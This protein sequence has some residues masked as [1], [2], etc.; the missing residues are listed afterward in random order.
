M[1]ID[2]SWKE[3]LAHTWQSYRY[4]VLAALLVWGTGVYMGTRWHYHSHP[5]TTSPESKTIPSTKKIIWTC[6]MDPQIRMPKPGKCPICSMDLI[7]VADTTEDVGSSSRRLTIS[8]SAK[9]LAEIRTS[10][11]QR[12]P[13]FLEV[14]MVGR[15]AYDET[16]IKT[17]TAWIPGRLE[18]MYV[19]YTGV[20][21]RRGDHLVKIY[22]PELLAAQQELLQSLQAVQRTKRLGQTGI[23]FDTA[24]MALFSAR[25]KLELLG[26]RRWQIQN[27]ENKGKAEDRVNIYSPIGGIVTQ[28]KALEGMYVQTGTPLY[29]IADLSQ[30]WV[31]F[32]AYER[33]LS[34]L[35]PGQKVTF[36]TLA[37]PGQH[38]EGNI[39]YIDPML[40]AQ[41]RTIGVR[42][43]AP[44][45]HGLLK[46]DMFVQGSVHVSLNAQGR[47]RPTDRTGQWICPMHP[48]IIRPRKTFCPLCG[49]SLERIHRNASKQ[50]DKDPLVIPKTAPLLT[51]KRAVVYVRVPKTDKPTYE[52]REII[53]GSHTDQFYVVLSGLQEGEEV[54]EHGAFKLDSELQ[55]HARPS[56]M[57]S[58]QQSITPKPQSKPRPKV[59]KAFL[60][61]L[62][63]VYRIYFTWAKALASDQGD[64]A[65]TIA[66]Q[67]RETVRSIRTHER[68]VRMIWEKLRTGL[69]EAA[70][71]SAK[72]KSIEEQ[73]KYFEHVSQHMIT[74]QRQ[75]GHS[76]MA[77]YF[78]AHCPMAFNNR[79]ASWLQSEKDI[80][81]PYFGKKMLTCGSIQQTLTGRDGEPL[82]TTAAFLRDLRPLYQAY[83]S[84]QQSLFRDQWKDA[85]KAIQAL[86]QAAIQ[87]RNPRLPTSHQPRWQALHKTL[88][89]HLQEANRA[90][91]IEDTRRA[92]DG[93]SKMFLQ[94]VYIFGHAEKHAIFEAYCPMAFNNRGAAWLQPQDQEV[95]NSYFG[96][97]MAHCGS[98]RR[99]FDPRS[100]NKQ[101]K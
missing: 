84:L 8:E 30:V 51:G 67:L 44:N 32:D 5:P 79:G 35:Y 16:R 88:Q 53:L 62:S 48:E 57:S 17:I 97:K 54:V 6:S 99:R 31:K 60:E 94:L 77:P 100:P 36:S 52:G 98:I 56:M 12:R 10:R 86:Q 90:K 70:D 46:P 1:R 63:H 34:W 89:T 13:V 40:D 73:R 43:N 92:F 14:R 23:V 74:L 28:K 87:Q 66:A 81:N 72:H 39:V 3:K 33:D 15:I 7:P 20:P 25:R 26:L 21:V 65:Q 45:S 47:A 76:G 29:T 64:T 9:T 69:F 83:F 41:T 68:D 18:R 101:R 24:R 4:L 37:A 2:G 82:E 71:H 78:L 58:S 50:E 42:V 22:S 49:M 75:L 19:D 27:I 55:I 91:Q 95:R 59:S 96:A 11:V 93:L 85:Q 38:F 61:K 80:L